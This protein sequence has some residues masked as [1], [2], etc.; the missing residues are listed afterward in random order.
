MCTCLW[1]TIKIQP[2]CVYLLRKLSLLPTFTIALQMLS[3]C[4][5]IFVTRYYFRCISMQSM[6]ICTYRFRARYI[7]IISI[8]IE[9]LTE[10]QVNSISSMQR[11][12]RWRQTIMH[13]VKKKTVCS[14][15]DK[16]LISLET[17]SSNNQ[18]NKIFYL[19]PLQMLHLTG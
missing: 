8:P 11:Y 6:T 12:Q 2:S 1:V 9:P 17:R 19:N 14:C 7:S 4:E 3:C 18:A 15:S 5:I 13:E 10:F 16:I